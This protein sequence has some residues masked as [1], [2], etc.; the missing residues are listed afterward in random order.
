MLTEQKNL[1]IVVLSSYTSAT[2]DKHAVAQ[3]LIHYL[4]KDTMHKLL[5]GCVRRHLQKQVQYDL[6]LCFYRLDLQGLLQPWHA[7]LAYHKTSRPLRPQ[8][9]QRSARLCYTAYY[10]S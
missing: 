2:A 4:L 5:L 7:L 1:H 9:I 8:K 3:E 10:N 6:H